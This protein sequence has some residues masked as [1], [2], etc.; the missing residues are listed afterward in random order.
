MQCAGCA[1]DIRIQHY[2]DKT[3]LCDTCDKLYC[4]LCWQSD[5]GPFR[6]TEDDVMT[7]T[8]CLAHEPGSQTFV[9]VASFWAQQTY[10]PF[11]SQAQAEHVLST[12]KRDTG[13]HYSINHVLPPPPRASSQE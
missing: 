13:V 12:M 2:L 11:A 9:I 7:C 8:R 3:G 6:I 5:R 4:M 1:E 10:G